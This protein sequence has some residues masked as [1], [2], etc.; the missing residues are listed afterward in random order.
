MTMSQVF[1]EPVRNLPRADVPLDGVTAFL[2]Q[3]DTHQI[4]FMEFDNDVDLPEHAHAAQAGIVV[5]GK[6]ELVIGGEKKC[7]TKGD[8]YHIPA[9]VKHSGKI[10]AGY[11]DMTFFDEPKRYS[12]A[13]RSDSHKP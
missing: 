6:I 4:V 11:A 10:Y 7:F 5:Q 13:K 12:A 2:S 1:P 3:A 8:V 9:G